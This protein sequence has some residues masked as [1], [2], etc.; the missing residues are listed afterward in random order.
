[1][2][3][4]DTAPGPNV[5]DPRPGEGPGVL[6][7]LEPVLWWE[8]TTSPTTKGTTPV[9]QLQTPPAA[10]S[11][12]GCGKS[13]EGRRPNVKRCS[14]KCR[15]T[16]ASHKARNT[17]R[18]T[19]TVYNFVGIDG[20]G[21][22]R[23]DGAHEYN[24]LSIGDE[25]LYHD[26]GSPLGLDEIL[27]F[28]WSYGINHPKSILIGFFLG[29]DYSQWLRM[30]PEER[31]RMLLTSAGQAARRRRGPNPAP[32]PVRW[33]RWEIDLLGNSKRFKVRLIGTSRWVYVMDVAPF[34]QCSLLK[35]INPKDWAPG[36]EIC[37][38]DEYE[39]IA[40][41]KG[42]RADVTPYGEPVD[43]ET[44][45]YNV[46][47]NRILA[48]L[49]TNLREGFTGFGVKLKRTQW[50]GPGQAAQTWMDGLDTGHTS[51]RIREVTPGPVLDAAQGSYFG[52]WFEIMAHGLVP[53][54]SHEYDINSAYPWIISQLPCLLHGTWRHQQPASGPTLVYGTAVGSDPY[55]G[56]M[57][58]R[59]PSGAVLRPSATRGW[60]WLHEVEASRRAGL[61]DAFTEEDRWSYD[62]CGCT[63]PF[64]PIA[65]L[66]QYRV[67]DGGAIKNTPKGKALKLVYNSA[68][69]KTAQSIGFPKFGNALYAS[70]ITAGCRTM[71]LEAIA[72][73]PRRSAAVVMVATDGVYFTEPHPGLRL[74]PTELGAWDHTP[75]PSLFLFKPGVYWAAQ[76]VGGDVASHGVTIKSRGVPAAGL[77][78]AIGEIEHRFDGL[79]I[80]P[81]VDAMLW[82]TVLI[83]VQ[84]AVTSP[85]A[86]LHR[87]AWEAAGEIVRHGT[88][89]Q[90]S[91]PHKKRAPWRPTIDPGDGT[92][93]TRPWSNVAQ[94]N[95][96]RNPMADKATGGLDSK[97][98]DRGFGRTDP[99]TPDGPAAM[100]LAE[101]LDLTMI[102]WD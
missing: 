57:P 84:F 98:Y 69:G 88:N 76:R 82:P 13:L 10:R 70:L 83:D 59:A 42:A 18:T 9:E 48:R 23:P 30:L 64:A 101:L 29:Y 87:N 97:P 100:L 22:N 90:S 14:P 74:S 72:S 24:L 92:M 85:R 50:H 73:H 102:E 19:S 62:P 17:A 55:I 11:C 46:L 35:A 7:H 27:R 81:P 58:H 20:E 80:T 86:A 1:M 41:G 21:V 15:P 31:G 96:R 34:F 79:G 77:A 40:R 78:A 89:L 75:R 6:E 51:D 60:F 71:I 91:A 44:V 47:E 26:D 43:P 12:D 61:L 63:P 33:N 37:T 28:V 25:S 53:G 65:A 54:V 5:K 32:F 8:N 49:M 39:A 94:R 93:R 16:G 52:G 38:A 36:T 67:A 4:E 95:G 66:Y 68:Y 99:D 3:M 2:P 45:A 56:P